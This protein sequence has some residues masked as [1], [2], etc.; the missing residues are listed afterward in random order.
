ML[1][2]IYKIRKLLTE[3]SK[4]KIY[5]L[6]KITT[7]LSLI[8]VFLP[9]QRVRIKMEF[10]T[11]DWVHKDTD[12][13]KCSLEGIPVYKPIFLPLELFSLFYTVVILLLWALKIVTE[14]IALFIKGNLIDFGNFIKGKN[15]KDFLAINLKY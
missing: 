10:F 7:L 15:L 2:S 14:Y 13:H 3:I 6:I 11:P 8:L 12:H 9:L 4:L 5:C 1:L